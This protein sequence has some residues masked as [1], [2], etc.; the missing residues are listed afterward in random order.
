MQDF[1]LQPKKRPKQ[2]RSK[3]TFDA[4]V[5][6]CT[7]VLPQRGY[8]GTTT[9]HIADAAG[10]GIASLYE[11]FPGKD[12]IIA[13]SI[14]H[15]NERVLNKL[16]AKATHIW[17]AQPDCL[18]PLWLKAIYEVLS[19]EKELLAVI[20]Y[21]IPYSTELYQQL[22]VFDQ[23]LAFSDALQKGARSVLSVQQSRESLYLI[24]DIVTH[25][26]TQLVLS[27]PHDLNS[28]DIISELATKLNH[29]IAN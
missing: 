7:K 14:R 19:E 17:G 8:A 18:M 26:L 28:E 10:V 13:Q 5:M 20:H 11:Y 15:F 2:A 21:Q 24:T 9:N 27:P 6:G 3:T 1:D 12:A 23:L 29:W 25:T 22:K 4:I 16:A